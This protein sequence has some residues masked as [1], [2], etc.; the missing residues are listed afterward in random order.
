MFP[1][2][3]FTAK[4]IY[5]HE[6]VQGLNLN[7]RFISGIEPEMPVTIS[8][9]EFHTNGAIKVEIADG[10]PF[11]PVSKVRRSIAPILTFRHRASS[12]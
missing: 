4:G 8:Y 12:I 10:N 3:S 9:S 1:V 6:P 11:T 2:R 5:L 7:R